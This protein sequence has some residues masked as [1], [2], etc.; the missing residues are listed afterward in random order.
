MGDTPE[1]PPNRLLLHTASAES[2]A[3]TWQVG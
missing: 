3:S 1:A 2:G